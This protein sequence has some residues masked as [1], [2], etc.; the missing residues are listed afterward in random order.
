MNVVQ[1]ELQQIKNNLWQP[2]QLV[3]VL[4]FIKIVET[5]L[6]I[7]LG[8]LGVLPRD[9]STIWH[10]FTMPFIHGDWGHLM[11]NSLPLIIFSF[12]VL[13]SYRQVALSIMSII[14]VLSGLGIWLLGRESYHIGASGVIYGLAFFIFFS[15]VF[16]RDVK[17]IALAL[18]VTLFYGGMVWGLLPIKEGVSW[19]GHLFGALAGVWCAYYYRH[20][21]PPPRF[22]WQDEKPLEEGSIIEDPFW[23]PKIEKQEIPIRDTNDVDS[24]PPLRKTTDDILK[25]NYEFKP[26]DKPE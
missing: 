1:R 15:G 24:P 16:R 22:A 4:W 17:S 8:W 11:S 26:K 13:Q 20:V 25:W 21:N 5:V 6:S 18:L 14:Y 3:G 19:E 23:I 9:F 12:I 10:I 7:D 2:I